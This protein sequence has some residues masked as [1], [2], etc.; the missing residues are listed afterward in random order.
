MSTHKP[1]EPEDHKLDKPE[2]IDASK[3]Y[4]ASDVR[5]SGVVV[6]LEAL[7]IF[8]VVTGLLAYGVGKG[9]NARMNKED[10]PPSRWV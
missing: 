4:E 6:F 10:G 1:H 5:V 3:G 8:A 9:L 2:E 7:S